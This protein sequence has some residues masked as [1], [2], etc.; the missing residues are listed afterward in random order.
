MTYLACFID[1]SFW[2]QHKCYI[3]VN[4]T[5]VK[6]LNSFTLC[7]YN[8]YLRLFFYFKCP[9][10]IFKFLTAEEFPRFK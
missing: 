3:N 4:F 9:D 10:C 2:L 7:E 1:E 8:H 6:E 5:K